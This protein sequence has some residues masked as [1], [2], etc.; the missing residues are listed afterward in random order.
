[1]PDLPG[2]QIEYATPV[3]DERAYFQAVADGRA[4]VAAGRV[5]TPQS[6]DDWIETVG[7]AYERPLPQS[8]AA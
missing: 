1:M 3:E 8:T 7:T 4:D 5:L 2:S 6:I